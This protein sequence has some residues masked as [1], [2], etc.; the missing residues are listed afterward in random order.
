[1]DSRR[2]WGIGGTLIKHTR[3]TEK[4]AGQNIFNRP[5]APSSSLGALSSW[6]EA[7]HFL[8]PVIQQLLD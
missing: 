7:S 6:M 5:I 2:T 3:K 1:M 4:G 8:L